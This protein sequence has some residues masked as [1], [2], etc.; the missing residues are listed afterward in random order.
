VR[1]GR[2]RHPEAKE[3]LGEEARQGALEAQRSRRQTI[4]AM[5]AIAVLAGA[6]TGSAL[7]L[8]PARDRVAIGW[9]VTFTPALLTAAL[10][11]ARGAFNTAVLLDAVGVAAAALAAAVD[12]V[13]QMLT[14]PLFSDTAGLIGGALLAVIATVVWTRSRLHQTSALS[15]R[16]H[17]LTTKHSAG[18]RL[19]RHLGLAIA[20]G[21]CDARS[22]PSDSP[23]DREQR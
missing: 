11:H 17:T 18:D 7:V 9:G 14:H 22:A 15:A 19:S 6:T 12:T 5:L 4:W 16:R 2:C 8:G 20:A 21:S 3:L 10:G 13:N 23:I 1:L